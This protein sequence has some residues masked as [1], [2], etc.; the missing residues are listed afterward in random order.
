[1]VSVYA[2]R[3]VAIATMHGKERAIAPALEARLGVVT[4]A[5]VG[6]DTDALG[7]FTGEI[8]RAGTMGEAAIAKARL[9]MRTAGV[10][11]AV[12]S[13]GSFGPHPHVPFVPCGRELLVFV[14]DED[15]LIISARRLSLATNFAS[16][17]VN[18]VED[19]GIFLTS[20]GF[21]DHAV[22]VRPN[23]AERVWCAK[24]LQDIGDLRRAIDEAQS[25]STDGLA[26]I[27]TDM[28]A[29]VNPTRMGEIAV[30]GTSLAERI[31]TPCP[32]CRTPGWG[33]VDIERGL[34]CNEC[35]AATEWVK[36]S[37][38]GCARCDATIRVPRSDGRKTIDAGH[39]AACNP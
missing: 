29:H 5:P 30:L 18:T 39:C 11:L 14:D 32:A 1:M 26:R 13:E 10:K 6:L 20:A 28:R 27:D 19:I 22:I 36:S 37:I 3:T 23:L 24:G 34:P 7:T 9:G 17:T 33:E 31:A 16:R 38:E 35:G 25:L 15:E 21:P 4:V 12:A 2:G 8:L